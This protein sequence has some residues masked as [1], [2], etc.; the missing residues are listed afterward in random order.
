MTTTE[1]IRADLTASMKAR[2]T[3]RTMTLRM[4]Q[5]ALQNEQIAKGSEFGEEDAIAV[6]GRAAKQRNEAIEQYEKAGRQDLADKE[7]REREIITAYLPAQL[8]DAEIEVIVK[9][10]IALLGAD[11]RKDTGRVIGAVMGKYKGQV[12]G[13]VVQAIAGKLLG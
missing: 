12:D 11:S 3:E 8:S 7:A 13:K 4:I 10:S 5:A 1:R 9:E 2:D 6:L